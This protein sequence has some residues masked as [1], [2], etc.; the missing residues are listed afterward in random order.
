MTAT[1]Q[2]S[3]IVKL[4]TNHYQIRVRATCPRT[5]RRKEVERARRCTLTEAKALQREWHDELIASLESARPQR[6]RL[7]D[8]AASWLTGKRGLIKSGT[9]KHIASVWDLHIATDKIADLYVD[10]IRPEDV[11]AWLAVMRTK[12]YAHRGLAPRTYRASTIRGAFEILREAIRVACARHRVPNPFD[13]V[14]AP[15]LG[16]S[17]ANYLAGDDAAKVIEYVREHEPGWYAATLVALTTGLRWSELSAL[18]FDD[19][20][21]GDQVIRVVRNQYEGQLQNSTKNGEDEDAPRVVP[22]LPEV[23]TVLRERRTQMVKDQHPGLT[24][25]WI[26]PTGS[27]ELH[28]STPLT[29]VLRRACDACGVRRIST[30]GLRH[31]ANDLLRRTTSDVVT[32]AIVGHATEAMSRHYSHVD[33]TEKFEAAQA[34]F[35]NV[36]KGGKKGGSR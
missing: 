10:D 24:E 15:K 11:E 4:G 29:K 23:A 18:R 2:N 20:D 16:R 12:T 35:G 30:H 14:K 19:L 34:A 9:A 36:I 13:A 27:G 3:G 25:G 33:E 5:G 8:F 6:I 7:R 31:T 22:L 21:E 32:R 1:K 17:R 28:H 26:F